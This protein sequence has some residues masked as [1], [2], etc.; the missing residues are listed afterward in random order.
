MSIL[1]VTHDIS[2]AY[3]VADRFLVLYA[4]E[5]SEV[6]PAPKVEKSPL[7]PYTRALIDS[8]PTKSRKEGRL[9]TIPGSTPNMLS[10]PEG[11]RF[12]PRCPMVMDVCRAHSPKFVDRDERSLRCFLYE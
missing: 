5:I 11:C 3:A 12:H 6:G 1:F 9:N 7:H 4:G 8:V 2:V 10:P